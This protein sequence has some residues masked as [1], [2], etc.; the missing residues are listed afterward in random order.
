MSALPSP[1][2]SY[3]QLLSR[4]TS[5]DS[6]AKARTFLDWAA[7]AET[8]AATLPELDTPQDLATALRWFAPTALLQWDWLRRIGHCA[9]GHR[10]ANARLLR[11][12]LDAAGLDDP[13]L[14]LAAQY[15]ALANTAGVH[16]PPASQLAGADAAFLMPC[17]MLSLACLPAERFGQI[18]GYSQAHG[19]LA[20]DWLDWLERQLQRHGL[21]LGYVQRY[22]QLLRQHSDLAGEAEPQDLAAGWAIYHYAQ[23]AG[24]AGLLQELAITPEQQAESLLQ[25]SA[26][27]AIGQHSRVLLQGRSLDQWLAEGDWP[28]LRLALA[29]SRYLADAAPLFQAMEFGGAMFGVFDEEEQRLLRCWLQAPP[30]HRS[31]APRGNAAPDAPRPATPAQQTAWL[32]HTEYGTQS[33]PGCIPTQER[34]NDEIAG[35]PGCIP[36]REHGSDKLRRLY[37]QLLNRET[38]PHSLALAAKHADTV[39]AWTRLAAPLQTGLRR[40]FPY[41]PAAFRQRLDAIHQREMARYRPLQGPPKLAKDMYVWGIVQMAPAI[42]LDGCWLENAAGAEPAADEVRRRLLRTFADEVGAGRPEWN[43]PNVYRCL[44]DSLRIALPT[45]DSREFAQYPGFSAA[46]FPLPLYLL[47]I[48]LWPERYFPELLGL[49][50]AIELS[51]LGAGYMQLVDALRYHGIDPSII[52]LHLSIDNLASGHTAL[53]REAIEAYLESVQSQGGPRALAPAWRRI[54]TGYQSLAIAGLPFAAAAL[55]QYGCR[56][57][58]ALLARAFLLNSPG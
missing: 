29:Q 11:A 28:A 35:V 36:T 20:G 6:L 7:S 56:Q 41:S 37:H 43:H 50:L 16:L 52:R 45:L 30:S 5:P 22:R 42:L 9:H 51:G 46:A 23:Q 53:A 26:P 18:L 58:K 12:Y 34:G 10:P 15:R 13:S 33:V 24:S 54:W 49:N 40:F 3:Q 4:E 25:R 8:G 2:R 17:A 55:K 21:P 38:H 27:Y 31:H 44:L 57:A 19:Q 32:G 47:T 1:R 14:A 48:G 39:L